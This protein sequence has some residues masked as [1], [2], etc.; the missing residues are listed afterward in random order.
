MHNQ[1]TE[2]C[3]DFEYQFVMQILSRI[4]IKDHVNATKIEP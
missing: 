4:G 2:E 3:H 1:K